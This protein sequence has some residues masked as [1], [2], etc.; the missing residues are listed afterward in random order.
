MPREQVRKGIT[1]VKTCSKCKELKPFDSFAKDSKRISGYQSRCRACDY[2]AHKEWKLKKFGE[3]KPRKTK[4]ES[5]EQRIEARIQSRR[6][7]T[8]NM[9]DE[10]RIKQRIARKKRDAM[11]L[12]N[13]FEIQKKR[14]KCS[15]LNGFRFGY[16]I[17]TQPHRLFGCSHQQLLK[18]VESQFESWMNWNNRGFGEAGQAKRN[19]NWQLD[20]IKPLNSAM[21]LEEYIAL[22]H[23]SNI[24]PL[25]A[26][27]NGAVKRGH[28]DPIPP[29]DSSG[30]Q[31]DTAGSFFSTPVQ[32]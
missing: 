13:E 20:H 12:N 32:N 21:N 3:P 14:L 26:Y 28:G 22:W 16:N 15:A 4:Y 18:H 27:I 6:M 31:C 7:F 19:F 8:M 10:Q 29:I 1:I 5:D 9:T 2:L 24:R 30:D 17:G 25:C 11:K 23:Y